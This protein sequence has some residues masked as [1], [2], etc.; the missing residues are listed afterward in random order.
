MQALLEKEKIEL[1]NMRADGA[2]HEA[3][4]ILIDGQRVGSTR[5]T[6][7]FG[8]W[9]SRLSAGESVE[10]TSAFD[11]SGLPENATLGRN[12]RTRVDL[13]FQDGSFDLDAWTI[14]DSEVARV[15]SESTFD[16]VGSDAT[17]QTHSWL[18]EKT[19]EVTGTTGSTQLAAGTSLRDEG[20]NLTNSADNSSG[21]QTTLSIL[22]SARLSSPTEVVVEFTNR[23]DALDR[24]SDASGFDS[25]I[26]DIVNVTGLDGFM[27][28]VELS[29]DPALLPGGSQAIVSWFDEGE[30]SDQDAW[31]N[32]TLGNSNIDSYDLLSNEVIIDGNN[33]LLDEYLE[34]NRFESSYSEYLLSLAPSDVPILGAFGFDEERLT[35]WAVIDHNSSFSTASISA[36]PEPSSMV[37]LLSALP[38]L[39]RRRR[40]AN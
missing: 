23:N 40:V 24:Q 38:W 19:T 16:I 6:V 36:V 34:G 11:D 13:T 17:R 8:D 26:S 4:A 20:L 27:H 33:L 39:F 10:L 3:E 5:W 14:G 28:V 1:E 12:F 2:G 31:V 30:N 22:D 18:L 15:N 7:D 21:E 9:D 25:L 32:A 29:Y 35:A 37:A